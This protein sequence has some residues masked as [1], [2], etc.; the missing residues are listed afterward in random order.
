VEIEKCRIAH[1]TGSAGIADR[2]PKSLHDWA[3]G[4]R[5]P[6]VSFSCKRAMMDARC[7]GTSGMTFNAA[8]LANRGRP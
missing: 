7:S 6:I 1:N 3:M 4:A 8:A 2:T 5:C